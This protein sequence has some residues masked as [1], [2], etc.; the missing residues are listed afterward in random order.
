M[1]ILPFITVFLLVFALLASSFMSGVGEITSTAKAH[2]EY[3]ADMR[4][5]RNKIETQLYEKTKRKHRKKPP[6][7]GLKKEKRERPYIS[8]RIRAKNSDFAKFNLFRLISETQTP[9]TLDQAFSNLLHKLYSGAIP[10]HEIELLKKKIL[11]RGQQKLKKAAKKGE[12]IDFFEL[13]ELLNVEDPASY[14]I[15]RGTHKHD[16][17]TGI[18]PL[19]EFV[20]FDKT[21]SPLYINLASP[22]LLLLL[23]GEEKMQKILFKEQKLK[24]GLKRQEFQEIIPE[25]LFSSMWLQTSQKVPSG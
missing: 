22:E 21:S 19:G 8:A 1:N 16:L 25:K 23:F 9:K 10:S 14:K 2:R 7:P 20:Y 15:L 17:T 4:A 11:Q 18:M 3:M 6:S 13:T 24:R 5:E 12:E